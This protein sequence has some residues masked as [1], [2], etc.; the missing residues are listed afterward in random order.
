LSASIQDE[1]H[2]K[3]RLRRQWQDTR[4]PALKAQV[5][6][7]QRLVIYRL[8]ERSNEQWSDTMEALDSEAKSL[9]KRTKRVM[10]VIE[11]VNEAMRAYEDGHAS[12]MKLTS[13]S[14][15]LQ[16]IKGPKVG[17]DQVPNGVPN[18]VRG[19]L[20]KRAIT[21]LAEV[22]NAVLRRQY[23][24]QHGNTLAWYP[25]R[26][27]ERTP[28]CCLPIDQFVHVILL[29]T[30]REDPTHEGPKESKQARPAA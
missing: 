5:N 14:E 15:V 21:F 30:L 4:V 24:P 13:P 27:R 2:L 29:A 20:P 3:N 22:F 7:F 6:R 19:H 1:I 17:K 18:R 11:I 8:N 16:A 26:S 9:W 12:E 23:F 10:R 28:R 25:Y